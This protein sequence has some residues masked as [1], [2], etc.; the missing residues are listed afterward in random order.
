MAVPRRLFRLPLTGARRA[1]AEMDEELEAHLALGVEYFRA[2]GLSP[3]EALR[4]ARARFG[5]FATARA[6]LRRTARLKEARVLRREWLAMM[7]RD[8]VFALRQMRRDRTMVAVVIATLGLGIGANLVV[9]D[10]VDRLLLSPPSH[11]PDPDRVVRPWFERTVKGFGLSAGYQTNWPGLQRMAAVSSF[12]NVAAYSYPEETSIGRGAAATS[13]QV[14]GASASLFA[15]LGAKPELGRF[16]GR[17]EDMPPSGSPVAVVSHSYYER[18]PDILG[19][20]LSIENTNYV[21]VGVAPT[22]F[23]GAE[24]LGVDIWIPLTSWFFKE[25]GNT[26]N[27]L[28]D[29][30]SYIVSTVAHLR[31]GATVERAAA[32]ASTIFAASVDTAST[33]RSPAPRVVLASIVAGRG[34]GPHSTATVTAWL[35]GVALVVLLV[36]CVNVVTL[37]LMRAVRRRGEIAIR[38]S[39]G[40]SRRR[41]LAQFAIEGAVLVAL[42]T[43]AAVLVARLAR[44]LVY[45]VLLPDMAADS[46]MPALHVAVLLG[47]LVLLSVLA[48][49]FAP[50]LHAATVDLSSAMKG[51]GVNKVARRS[52]LRGALATV[53]VAL[54]VVLLVGAA[55]FERSLANVRAV[56]LGLDVDRDI[57]AAVQLDNGQNAAAKDQFWQDAMRH[58]SALPSVERAT[59]SIGVPFRSAMVL[60]FRLGGGRK[61]PHLDTG[62]PYAY[63]VS[64]TFFATLGTHVMRGRQFTD[65]DRSGAQRVV[66]VN[67]TLAR[68]AWPNQDPIGACVSVGSDSLPCATIVGVVQDIH[69]SSVIESPMLQFYVPISQWPVSY[70]ATAMIV[71]RRASAASARTVGDVRRALQSVEA[72]VPYPYVAPFADLVDPQLSSW[73]LGARMFSLFGGLAFAVTLMGLYGL[74]AHNVAERRH[75]L[76]VRTALGARGR[77]IVALIVL[78]GTR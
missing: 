71:R 24:L 25:T 2:R 32:Q 21:V 4:A 13:A 8:L 72:D 77:D 5:D 19:K 64:P 75:E 76:G 46:A 53:Q 58:V 59:L 18:H 28:T 10:V 16:Y 42:S 12:D 68:L 40:V 45:A 35:F 23:T 73:L 30:G 54:S 33:L 61:P 50:A 65:A 14:E 6:T 39:L 78:Q 67:A 57:V 26:T 3:D 74:L 27:Y 44:G 62:G 66:I 48:T 17:A 11:V 51:S 31:A 60:R 34:P 63:G 55:L 20:A 36:A 22:G 41:L 9:F 15:M 52:R 56:P 7:S 1:E 47:G 29:D 38:L 37:L 69:R 43:A 49:T 70:W